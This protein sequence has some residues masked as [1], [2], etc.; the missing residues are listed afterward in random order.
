MTTAKENF[1]DETNF[2]AATYNSSD[3]GSL[4]DADD[5]VLQHEFVL[6]RMRTVDFEQ[7]AQHPLEVLTRREAV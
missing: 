2:S 6:R 3:R 1:R 4:A 7:R 5:E